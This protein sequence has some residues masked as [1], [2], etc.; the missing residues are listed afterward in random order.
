MITRCSSLRPWSW[1]PPHC[2]LCGLRGRSPAENFGF[3]FHVWILPSPFLSSLQS[4]HSFSLPTSG[5]GWNRWHSL[6]VCSL[7]FYSVVYTLTIMRKSS[8]HSTLFLPLQPS[9]AVWQSYNFISS[10]PRSPC[11]Q[12]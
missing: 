5:F 11:S 7:S 12:V 3:H 1:V 8:R 2:S 9:D 6:V 10:F 4:S